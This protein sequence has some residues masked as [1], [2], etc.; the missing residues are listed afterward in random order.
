MSTFS[1]TSNAMRILLVED[2]VQSMN[3][4]KRMLHDLGITQVYTAKD[5]KEAL[6][7]LG[8]FDGEEIVDLILCDWNMPVVSG[9]E[10]LSQI[11]SCDSDILFIM[12]TGQADRTSVI[13]AKTR[14]ISGYIKKPFSADELRKKIDVAARV[15]AHR[16]LDSA[17]PRTP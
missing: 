13:E 6:D 12:I 11:R 16:K 3:L 5:G 17:R 2:N 15:I 1:A 10:L 7:L 9:I 4:T 14:G 8:T